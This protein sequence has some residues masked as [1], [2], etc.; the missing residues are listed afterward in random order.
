MVGRAFAFNCPV[1]KAQLTQ[2]TRP[3]RPALGMTS[4]AFFFHWRFL[5]LALLFAGE[6][7]PR[8]CPMLSTA[9]F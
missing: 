2:M 7:R 8:R 1:K 9:V 4:R 6:G 5:P 3:L